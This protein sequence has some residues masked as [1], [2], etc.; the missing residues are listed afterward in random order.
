MGFFDIKQVIGAFKEGKIDQYLADFDANDLAI[1]QNELEGYSI[2]HN[3]QD[4]LRGLLVTIDNILK[5]N[6]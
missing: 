3:R 6:L 2:R 1:L 5:E 4:D